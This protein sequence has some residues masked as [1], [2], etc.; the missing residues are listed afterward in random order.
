VWD[1]RFPVGQNEMLK[2][3]IDFDDMTTSIVGCVWATAVRRWDRD[4]PIGDSW[5]HQDD[6]VRIV[7]V[8]TVSRDY[9]VVATA[10]FDRQRPDGRMPRISR[11]THTVL[12]VRRVQKGERKI[13]HRKRG[14]DTVELTCDY[15]WHGSD[16]TQPDSIAEGSGL[17]TQFGSEQGFYGQGNY[18]AHQ[19]SYSHHERYV[20]RSSDDEGLHR[21]AGGQYFQ[22]LLVR[23]LRG[24]PLKTTEVWKPPD[25]T[26]FRLGAVQDKL[27]KEFD[28]VEGG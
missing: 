6:D 2:C 12:K 23:V 11:G 13:M 15:A 8:E 10:F 17:M 9:A 14:K 24:N 1:T 7:V 16:T 5:D 21:D 20:Y 25:G 18:S 26:G 22:L 28:S 27:G 3:L 19:A 4:V